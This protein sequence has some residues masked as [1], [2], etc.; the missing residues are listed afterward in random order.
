MQY[1]VSEIKTERMFNMALQALDKIEAESVPMLY[2]MDPHKLMRSLE[3][4]SIL[5]V[6]KIV[7]QAMKARKASGMPLNSFLLSANSLF[8]VGYTNFGAS[9][10]R[11]EVPRRR[12]AKII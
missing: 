10:G 9:F 6:A 3:D 2:A 12:Q 7:I 1:Y 8:I 4:V 11:F 5:N